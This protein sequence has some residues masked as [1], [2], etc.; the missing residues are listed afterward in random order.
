M[1][2]VYVE[3]LKQSRLS[4]TGCPSHSKSSVFISRPPSRWKEEVLFNFNHSNK[5]WPLLCSVSSTKF[6]SYSIS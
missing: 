1:K 3:L 2:Y 6:S 5:S 4:L